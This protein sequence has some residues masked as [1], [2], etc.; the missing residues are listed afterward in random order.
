MVDIDEKQIDNGFR[1]E[2]LRLVF[3]DMPPYDIWSLYG[4][5]I[6]S[7]KAML[8]FEEAGIT[9]IDM[10]P[11]EETEWKNLEIVMKPTDSVTIPK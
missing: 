9:G 10:I 6:I 4:Q 3:H 8:L 5:H 7:A 11:L 1:L 2:P